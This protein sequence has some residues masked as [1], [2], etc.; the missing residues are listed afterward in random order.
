MLGSFLRAAAGCERDASA[1]GADGGRSTFPEGH[2]EALDHRRQTL[3]HFW[4]DIELVPLLCG[5]GF[6]VSVKHRNSQS[7]LSKLSSSPL[8]PLT[9][10]H[11]IPDQLP[12]SPPAGRCCCRRGCR[13]RSTCRRSA[14]ACSSCCCATDSDASA[15]ASSSCCLVASYRRSRCRASWHAAATMSPR[16]DAAAEAQL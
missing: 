8:P 10:P 2:S 16:V 1:V 15:A 11:N 9:H 12:S 5:P 4:A 14:A 3:K 6:L 13:I 7:W